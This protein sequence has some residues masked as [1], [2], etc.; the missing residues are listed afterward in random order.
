MLG[1][2]IVMWSFQLA[3]RLAGSLH[4]QLRTGSERTPGPNP[5]PSLEHVR[6]IH[7]QSPACFFLSIVIH[8]EPQV[9][10]TSSG[11][12][13]LEWDSVGFSN[14]QI[15][16]IWISRYGRAETTSFST[17][18]LPVTN[19]GCRFKTV[20]LLYDCYDFNLRPIFVI[21]S[22]QWNFK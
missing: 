4:P 14:R 15:H 5:D 12:D 7:D 13:K 10:Q 16:S 18:A 8:F 11:Q 9:N 19:F 21:F 6:D 22:F 17:C 1:R 2:E 20:F 3:A